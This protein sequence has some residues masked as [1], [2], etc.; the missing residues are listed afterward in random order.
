MKK[1]LLVGSCAGFILLTSG[2]MPVYTAA[3]TPQK[4]E[5]KGVHP[6]ILTEQKPADSAAYLTINGSYYQ[7]PEECLLTRSYGDLAESR[8]FGDDA[9]SRQFGDDAESRNYGDMADNRKFGDDAE[10][11]NFGDDAESR[12]F[13]DDAE[14]RNY[15]D[16][17][18]NRKFGDDAESRNFGD[19]AESRQFGDDAE[20]RNYGDM[21]DNRK[22][23]DD[24]ESRNFGD[25]AESR[26][27]G[28]L[29]T[30]FRCLKIQNIK[31]VVVSGFIGQETILVNNGTSFAGYERDGKTILLKF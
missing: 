28:E 21:A 20:S 13:G 23:G 27:F 12:Q 1:Q 6:L 29:A 16:M 24:A 10:S 25:D 5:Y 7:L 17:A 14:S 18:D 2:C 22:F 3:T 30:Q 19:D 31:S 9:E 4:T 8:N 15:G 11:R 26:Q